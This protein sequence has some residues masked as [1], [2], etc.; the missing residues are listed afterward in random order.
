MAVLVD[1]ICSKCDER[2]TDRWSTMIDTPHTCGGHWERW[3]TLTRGL[4]PGTHPSEKVVV[5]QSLK[6]GGAVQYPGRSDV[7]VPQRLR[8]RGYERVELNVRD[9]APFEK[10]HHVANERRHYDRNGRGF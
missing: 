3:W 1:V 7:P 5:Y 9:L 2:Q 4:D 10:K 6:E 8:Q